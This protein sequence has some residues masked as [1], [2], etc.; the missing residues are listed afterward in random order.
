[1]SSTLLTYGNRFCLYRADLF[2]AGYTLNYSKI[3]PFLD[4]RFKVFTAVKIQV[5]VFWVVTPCSV[6]VGRQRFETPCRLHLQ[7]E[8]PPKR[9]YPIA[10]LHCVTT[11]MTST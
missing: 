5:E 1:M 9:W 2:S 3:F 10:A 4:A 6:V 7:G 8:D 11:Q